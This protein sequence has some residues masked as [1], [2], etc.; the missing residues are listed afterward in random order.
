VYGTATVKATPIISNE[1]FWSEKNPPLTV[2]KSIYGRLVVD[3]NTNDFALPNN[4]VCESVLIESSVEEKAT[5]TVAKGFDKTINVS[6]T[7]TPSKY[8]ILIS[9]FNF[10]LTNNPYL[11]RVQVKAKNGQVLVGEKKTI[12]F[13]VVYD[14]DTFENTA[15]EVHELDASG[16]CEVMVNVP[17]NVMKTMKFK[18]SVNRIKSTGTLI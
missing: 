3:F 2:T 12:E 18:V 11:I 17:E 15:T 10:F 4:K 6:S 16:K 7:F 13:Q 9:N 8:K 5:G 14:T 1:K